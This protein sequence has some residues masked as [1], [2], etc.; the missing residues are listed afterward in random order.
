MTT[1]YI[2]SDG[3][4]AEAGYKSS[5]RDCV[6]RAICNATGKDYKEI[7]DRVN[8]FIGFYEKNKKSGSRNGVNNRTVKALME[9]WGFSWTACMGI[10]TGC[11]VHL[12]SD[13][14]PKGTIICNLSRHLTCVK[15]GIIY[16]TYDCSREGTRCVY[17]Y[18]RMEE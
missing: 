2:Y 15:D 10:G 14:L 16:D 11:K 18:W 17:G 6:V 9:H 4:R 3:G 7:Y 5:A 12:K 1:K 8:N 13:E